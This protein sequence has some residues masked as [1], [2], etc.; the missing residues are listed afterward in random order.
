[1]ELNGID[2][3]LI[4][5]FAKDSNFRKVLIPKIKISSTHYYELLTTTETDKAPAV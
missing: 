5:S 2:L 1:M 3:P 4:I